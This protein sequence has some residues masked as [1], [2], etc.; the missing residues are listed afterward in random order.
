MNYVCSLFIA[1]N[2]TIFGVILPC[3]QLFFYLHA[4]CNAQIEDLQHPVKIK[5]TELQLTKTY[6]TPPSFFI[7]KKIIYQL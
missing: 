1:A 4:A 5:Y 6:K 7:S 2:S 3:L